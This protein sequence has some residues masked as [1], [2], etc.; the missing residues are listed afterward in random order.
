MKD[1]QRTKENS[2]LLPQAVYRQALYA[3]KDLIRLK[4]KLFYLREISDD[5][6]VSDPSEIMMKGGAVSDVTGN[7]ATEISLTEDRIMA[8]ERAFRKLPEKYR[9]GIIDKLIYDVPYDEGLHCINTWK[10]WQQVLIYYVAVN[11]NLL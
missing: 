11:L 5:L 6:K 2:Y 10:K 9:E 1:Y 7:I 4:R 8:I 3:V